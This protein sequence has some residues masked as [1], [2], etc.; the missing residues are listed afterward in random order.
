M[1]GE[2]V[3][4]GRLGVTDFRRIAQLMYE[5][6]SRAIDRTHAELD[7][8]NQMWVPID[9]GRLRASFVKSVTPGQIAM[10]WSAVDPKTGFNYAKVQD[11]GD[12]RGRFPGWNFSGNMMEKA[13]ELLRKYL[14]MELGAMTP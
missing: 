8:F 12:S 11:E 3:I 13:K 7:R 4:T 14:L 9:T 2:V 6:I 10:R 5:A 1:S